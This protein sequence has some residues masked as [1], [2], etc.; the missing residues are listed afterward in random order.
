MNVGI[1]ELKAHL[2]DY[3]HRAAAGEVVTITDRGR[4]VARL[5]ACDPHGATKERPESIRKLIAEGRVTPARHRGP[6]PKV[7]PFLRLPEG[8]TTDM[9]LAQDREDRL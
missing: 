4:P 9:L 5:Q 6:L 7:T 3:V 1:R 8:V 2:S